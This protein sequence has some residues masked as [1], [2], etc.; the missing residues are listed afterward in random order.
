[1]VRIVLFGS[2]MQCF[3]V[4]FVAILKVA[5]HCLSHRSLVPYRRKTLI[6]DSPNLLLIPISYHSSFSM[7][8]K[9]RNH[10]VAGQDIM[11]D[12]LKLTNQ[13]P[14]VSGESLQTCVAWRCLD[15]AQHLFCLPI[16]A[17]SGQSLDPVVQ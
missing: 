5:S 7:R 13:V 9:G 8:E 6:I 10:L 3:V 2:N 14:R 16:L 4:L 15:G 17:V 11:M 1:M 12:A